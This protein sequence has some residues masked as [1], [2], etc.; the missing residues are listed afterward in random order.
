M[1]GA[2]I[3]AVAANGYEKTS[4][5]QVIGLAGVSRRS[6][7]EQFSN[8]RDCFLATFDML[9]QRGLR[10]AG[11]ACLASDGQADDR[12]RAVFG[13]L[14]RA[15][16]VQPKA[17]G[18]VIVEA[19]RIGAA[20][21]MRL[22]QAMAGCEQM[23][24]RSFEAS[25]L[26]A[27]VIRGI[28][29]GLHGAASACLRDA[30]ASAAGAMAEEMV[31][32][33]MLFQTSAAGHMGERVGA[34]AMREAFATPRVPDRAGERGEGARERIMQEALRL[35]GTEGLHGLTAPQIAAEAG[36]SIDVFFEL[37][38]DRDGCFMAA[39]EMLGCE[40][41]RAAGEP[42]AACADWPRAVRRSIGALMRLLGER[43]HYAQTI[44][45]GAFAAGP[46]ALERN[47]AIADAVTRLLLEGAPAE[48]ASELAVHGVA[49]AIS[50]TVRCQVASGRVQLLPALSDYLS[51]VVLAPFI[52]AEAA[53]EVVSEDGGQPRSL[54]PTGARRIRAG[55]VS[56]GW[57]GAPVQ[58][59]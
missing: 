29:G 5:K 45:C 7:Y 34:R 43:E 1:H 19:P 31:R 42:L 48:A 33:T 8:K 3:E 16:T 11:D 15:I 20:G 18:L 2:M 49:G 57:R 59:A 54:R 6:F 56:A 53:V 9:A 24:C 28:A 27:P 50:H 25:P 37:F 47:L 46:V 58:P 38:A 35:A 36:V 23:L 41:L 30:S 51:Y 4:V 55:R 21:V 44:A 14:A 10:R 12:L 40:L 52:G 39:L 22:C 26:P 13:E 32:W 17:A